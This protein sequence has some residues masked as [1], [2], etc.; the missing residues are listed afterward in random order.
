MSAL[1][2]STA[3]GAVIPIILP[4]TGTFTAPVAGLVKFR[5]PHKG[6]IVRVG[7]SVKSQAG[8]ATLTVD[9]Q[10]TGVS[11]L[12]AP[13]DLQAVADETYV[14]SGLV[15][16]HENDLG[17]L[18]AADE[19]ITVDLGIT[20]AGAETCSHITVQIDFLPLD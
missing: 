10:K 7:A 2:I 6:A 4:L 1:N 19:E 12:D 15:L 14:E 16:D 5:A 9:V 13:I 17:T 3:V 20:G 11:I 8:T 18:V